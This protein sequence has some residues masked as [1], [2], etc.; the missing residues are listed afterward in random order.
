M[1]IADEILTYAI[2]DDKDFLEKTINLNQEIKDILFRY[3]SYRQG[4]RFI[5][6]LRI[7]YTKKEISDLIG[8][9]HFLI[10][11]SG[12]DIS[13]YEVA[14]GIRRFSRD[15]LGIDLKT[16]ALAYSYSQTYGN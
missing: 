13:V 15:K 12:N 11:G 3:V 9:T 6:F 2:T 8:A 16:L 14:Q 1:S 4:V 7:H 5:K 10:R